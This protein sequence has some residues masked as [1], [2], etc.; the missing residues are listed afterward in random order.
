MG[1]R[2]TVSGSDRV[3]VLVVALGCLLVFSVPVWAQQASGIA[4]LV[5]D[6]SG[7]VLPGVTVEA[8]SP[9]LIEKVRSVVTDGEGRYNIV[10][11]RPGTYAVTFTL[12]GFR[13]LRRDEIELSVGFTASV[14]AD[15]QVG[16]LEET[17]TVSG[18][19]PLVDTQNA[20]QQNVV[21][22][23]MLEA[24][25]TSQMSMGTLA[26]LTPGMNGNPDVG[27]SAGTYSQQAQVQGFHGKTNSNRI[28][29]D[30]MRVSNMCGV[31]SISYI[32]NGAMVEEMVVETGG[33]TAESNSSSVLMNAVP[34]EGGN[35]FR[36]GIF[37]TYSNSALQSENLNDDLRARG[38]TQGFETTLMYH[39]D[40]TVGGPV[41]KDK[42]W[43][44]TAQRW[45]G[46]RNKTDVY[47]NKTQGTPVY[48]PDLS[49]PGTQ[50]EDL[51]SNAVRLTWQVSQKNKINAFVDV[52]Q[53]DMPRHR[54]ST[55]FVAPEAL[56]GWSFPEPAGRQH[57]HRLP[58][59]ADGDAVFVDRARADVG[60]TRAT[61][62]RARDGVLRLG[63]T[64][65]RARGRRAGRIE[66]DHRAVCATECALDARKAGLGLRGVA[67][68]LEV[69]NGV[70]I[71]GAIGEL[72][73]DRAGPSRAPR[74]HRRPRRQWP[75][76]R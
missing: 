38:I 23:D 7:A 19:A 21:G 9:V 63:L 66:P 10:D 15:M 6:T 24:L 76:L 27:G 32:I 48:T 53:N 29:Y 68:D 65:A 34:K 14:N 26:N 20:R 40:A 60:R 75:R 51:R 13:T 45:T 12:P 4:G 28:N 59:L 64:S 37:G 25:P 56:P 73:R 43:F 39:F 49:R 2:M 61:T 22:K 71:H 42:L 70:L 69:E 17:I 30:G 50:Q 47:W 57:P 31:S 44:F 55:G 58:G 33:F 54:R 11:L 35:T 36:G 46:N 8:A 41:K 72:N 62:V 1:A 16:A 74:P 3:R 67:T 52:Q 5:K 18:A